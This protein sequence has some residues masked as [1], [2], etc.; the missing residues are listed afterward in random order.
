MNKKKRDS[1]KGKAYM[2]GTAVKQI[3]NTRSYPSDGW[4]KNHQT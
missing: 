2:F 3:S 4:A 1:S